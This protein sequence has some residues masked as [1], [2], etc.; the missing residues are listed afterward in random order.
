MKPLYWNRIQIPVIFQQANEDTEKEKVIWEDLDDIPIE[1]EEFDSLFSRNVVKP[2]PKEE[3][4]VAKPKSEKPASIIDSKRSQ[5]I[6]ILL[7]STH[8]DIARIEEVVYQF[9][10]SVDA[11][12]LQQVQEVQATPDE[13]ESIRAHTKTNPEKP[14]DTPDQFLLDL[15]ALSFFN[16]R[17][18]C[19]MFQTKFSDAM[20]EIENRLNNIRS[21][22]D[23]LTTSTSMKNMFAVTLACGNYMNGGNRQRGQADGFSIEILPKIKDVKSN[24]NTLNL[25]AYIVRFCILKFDENRG[26]QEATLPVPEPS[27]LEKCQHIDF[28]VERGECG[29]VKRQ[30][31][32][33]KT[34]TAKIFEKSPEELK[35]P[36]NTKMVEFVTTA[37]V[38]L[39]DLMELVEDCEKRF[40]DT[41]KFYK[42]M[43]KKGKL[44]EAK[45]ADFFCLWYPFCNDYKNLWKKEQ[46]RIQKELLKEER[47]RHKKK[48]ESLQNVEIKKTPA[49]GLKAKLQRRKTQSSAMVGGSGS[50]LLEDKMREGEPGGGGGGEGGGLKAKL[51]KRKAK[52]AS[53]ASGSSDIPGLNSSEEKES[54]KTRLQRRSKQHEGE[55]IAE[56]A[57][58]QSESGQEILK[59]TN[60]DNKG[61]PI[62]QLAGETEAMSINSNSSDAALKDDPDFF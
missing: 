48:K 35:E 23:F 52:S 38:Q 43:P 27:D 8:L 34:S 50:P 31:E 3:K 36:F 22:C 57:S 2:K 9:E 32:K 39:T 30:L 42:F 24:T 55:P 18:T 21:C 13:L 4:K 60:E 25:L 47:Q 12:V 56:E 40:I 53:A 11:E 29:K 58:E 14:L 41:M 37:E 49:G 61:D 33:A 62:E 5:N 6:G 26:T 16:E 10:L 15:A 44:E 46:V 1:E 7:R 28:E 20:A 17:I 19:I 51:M 59:K 45:P 54:L